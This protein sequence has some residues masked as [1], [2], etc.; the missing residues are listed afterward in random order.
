MRTNKYPIEDYFAAGAEASRFI[1][2]MRTGDVGA[3]PVQQ[4]SQLQAPAPTTQALSGNLPV[5]GRRTSSFHEPNHNGH[6]H[7]GLDI[8][9]PIGTPLAATG[10]GKVLRAGPATGFGFAVYIDHGNGLITIYG[11]ISKPLV[12]VGQSVQKGTIIA[13]SGNT[14]Q[15]SGPHVHYEVRK[16][17]V[18]I[19][20]DTAVLPG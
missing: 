4:T 9:I 5:S 15:S 1:K 16:N 20:P 12:T 13:L 14:G 2:M 6:V 19:D 8:A 3:A 11:H 18:A 10:S 17:G 7:Q